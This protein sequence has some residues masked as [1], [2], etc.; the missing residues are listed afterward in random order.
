VHK[1]CNASPR[2]DTAGRGLSARRYF[3]SEILFS[4]LK[5]RHVTGCLFLLASDL[6]NE[7]L[8]GSEV[9]HHSLELLL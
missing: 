4:R 6:L 7:T 5:R 2:R 8:K 9:P 3:I 1:F